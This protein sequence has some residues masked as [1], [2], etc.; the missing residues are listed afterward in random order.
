MSQM[1]SEDRGAVRVLTL[2]RPAKRNAL[3]HALSI[4]LLAA[5]KAADADDRVGAIVLTGAGPSFCA[6]ADTAEFGSLTPA[7]QPLVDARAALTAELHGLFPILRTPVVTAIN[8]AAMGGGAG[9]AVAGD[10]ALM[11]AS[12]TLGYP[13]VRHGIVAAIVM[14]SLV[15]HVGRKAAFALL[16]TARPIGAERALAL[17]MVTEVVAD[18]ELMPRA[19]ATAEAL[20][21]VDRQAM[22]ATKQLFYEV[23]DKPF[24]DALAAGE[25]MNRRMRAFRA[26]S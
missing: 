19:L 18:A 17:G 9:L 12:A 22:I 13:E 24:A 11:A 23:L 10:M 4:E 1:L 6:G 26:G 3:D 2:N 20:A 8:G 16:A 5:L 15:R 7:N 21:A 14:P 25:S